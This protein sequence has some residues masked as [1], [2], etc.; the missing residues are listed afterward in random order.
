[1]RDEEP[2]DGELLE[3]EVEEDEEVEVEI[4]ESGELRL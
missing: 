4:E 1:M 2:P 3:V